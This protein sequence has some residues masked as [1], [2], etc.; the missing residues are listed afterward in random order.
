MLSLLSLNVR[1]LKNNVKRKAIFLYCK[2]Q[3]VD[4]IFMQE[5]HSENEDMQFWKNQWG[6]S[7]Y[8][9][10]GT[11]HSAGVMVLF[12]RF[13]GVV[14]DHKEDSNGHWLMV[15]VEIDHV[16]IIL[17][18]VYGYNNKVMNR[19]FYEDLCEK[20][21]HW[22][23]TYSCEQVIMGGDFNLVPDNSVD[24]LPTRGHHHTDDD[25][26]V[27]LITNTHLVDCWRSRNHNIKQYTWFNASNNGQCSRLDYWLVPYNWVDNVFQCEISAS[28]LTDHCAVTLGLNINNRKPSFTT[29][30]KFNSNL[31][32][33]ELFCTDIRNL[34]VEIDSLDSTPLSKWEWFK[35]KVRE[36]A[37]K[38]GKQASKQNR[39]K[40][41]EIVSNINKLCTKNMLLPEE[42]TQLE[43]LK[44][45][46]DNIYVHKA[47]GAFV[48]SR[49]RWI[50]E[51]EK[52]S[53]Y[54]FNLEKQRQSKKK[55]S[56]LNINGVVTDNLEEINRATETFYSKL[57][58][59]RFSESSCKSFFDSIKD[60]RESIQENF[61]NN[62][63]DNLRI[64]ELDTAI[65]Q[66]S[67][68]KSPG[69]DGLTVEFYVFF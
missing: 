41:N 51:G 69:L 62:M 31:L 56:K 4:C 24:R 9:S 36:I 59:T 65:H 17:V 10:H 39:E 52:N 38:V 60:I 42:K 5:T 68:G 50:E 1:G 37:I 11:S 13:S 46:L 55:I 53:S 27:M 30:W 66:M 25:T 21:C 40:Q 28:P 19:L 32:Y 26:F 22:K 47:R 3:K 16:K 49:A 18:C 67:K 43:T 6:N 35:F 64:E 7:V 34:L 44:N 2:E 33:N 57:Y 15:V 54:F 8:F 23:L 58:S 29:S 14:L 20:I 12:S 48:R 45:Q 63:E 61:K